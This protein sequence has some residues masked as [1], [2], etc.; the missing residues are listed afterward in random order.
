MSERGPPWL[1]ILTFSRI[2]KP[3]AWSRSSRLV[4]G[5]APTDLQN[6]GLLLQ[7][8]VDDPYP[9]IEDVH[10]SRIEDCEPTRMASLQFR[11][12]HPNQI[13]KDQASLE[14]DQAQQETRDPT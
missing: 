13:E 12:L 11:K 2:S 1:Q 14:E 10:S 6:W 3:C 5:Q 4:S 9:E 8:D 7:T